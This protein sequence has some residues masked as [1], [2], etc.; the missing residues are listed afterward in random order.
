MYA[1]AGI[2]HDVPENTVVG[3]SPAFEAREWLRAWRHYRLPEM[4]K[5]LRSLERRVTELTAD[6][7]SDPDSVFQLS[8]YQTRITNHVHTAARLFFIAP[9][10]TKTRLS[11]KATEARPLRILSEY[12][13]PLAHF[14]RRRS[15]TRSCSLDR[16][17]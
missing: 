3:G 5:V 11:S 4:W 13:W 17:D 15:R 1:Q 8:S 7:A 2:G 14:R 12:L 10:H 16:P 9:S 6:E